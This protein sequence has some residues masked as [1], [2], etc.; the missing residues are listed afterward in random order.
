[1]ISLVLERPTEKE[2]E[3]HTVLTLGMRL[4]EHH[5]VDMEIGNITHVKGH[6]MVI[7]GADVVVGDV[8]CTVGLSVASGHQSLDHLENITQFAGVERSA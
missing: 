4:I 1:M 3:G 8:T 7:T 5:V 2:K 6:D